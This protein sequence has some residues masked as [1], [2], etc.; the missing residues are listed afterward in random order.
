MP[1]LSLLGNGVQLKVLQKPGR[2]STPKTMS[3]LVL[4]VEIAASANDDQ[5][6]PIEDGEVVVGKISSLRGVDDRRL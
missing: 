2:S 5:L 1:P 6:V 3:P 4:K